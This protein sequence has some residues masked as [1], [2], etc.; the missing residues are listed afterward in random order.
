MTHAIAPTH[1]PLRACRT[2]AS[3]LSI[4]GEPAQPAPAT[5]SAT[6]M[7]R[8]TGVERERLRTWERRHGFPVP[9]R[10]ANNVRRY[11]AEDVRRVSAIASASAQGVPLKAAIAAI[12][13]APAPGTPSVEPGAALSSLPSPA[14]VVS[15]PRPL[16]VVWRNG[17]AEASAAAPLVGE[18][19]GAD[20]S[21]FGAVGVE[22]LRRLMA[23]EVTG[24]QTFE[25]RDWTT[26]TPLVCRV[27][28]WLLELPGGVPTAVIA[29]LP[30]ATAT[31]AAPT[32]HAGPVSSAASRWA[33]ALAAGRDV[34]RRER[35]LASLQ[36]A[37]AATSTAIGASDAAIA[38]CHGDGLRVARSVRGHVAPLTAPLEGIEELTTARRDGSPAWLGLR[39][40]ATLRLDPRTRTL[41]VPIGVAD[42]VVGFALFLLREEAALCPVTEELLLGYGSALGATLERERSLRAACAAGATT[43]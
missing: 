37:L 6:E 14:I 41:A 39:A 40:A 32:T 23:G 16:E 24:P 19:L 12:A 31:P 38:L 26:S 17:A 9:V 42:Q 25:A 13:A 3:P 33:Q 20:P 34:L 43:P 18:D 2:E 22:A 15:G 1:S 35:G 5:I 8:L 27:T 11:R 28:A 36:R 29:Q 10:C 7:S 21:A 30:Q 4:V